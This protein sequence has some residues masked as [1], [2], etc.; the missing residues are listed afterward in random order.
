MGKYLNKVSKLKNW[1]NIFCQDYLNEE[2]LIFKYGFILFN[3]GIFFLASAPFFGTIFILI[4]I[5]LSLINSQIKPNFRSPTNKFLALSFILL[6]LNTFFSIFFKLNYFEEWNFKLN[7]IGLLNWIPFFVCFIFI[8]PYL[9]NL[10]YRT[11]CANLLLIGSLPVI[12]SGLCE[13]FLGWDTT[14]RTL[15]GSI[16]W[17]LKPINESKGMSGLFSNPNYAASWLIVIWPIALGAFIR[18]F[19]VTLKGLISSIT[20]ILFFFSILLTNSKD[21][22]LA[23]FIPILF[24]I[25]LSFLRYLILFLLVFGTVFVIPNNYFLKII[26]Y[27]NSALF[28]D[29]NLE[30]N[31]KNVIDYFPRLDI[32]RVS[33][34]AIF[35]K[36]ILGWGAASFPLIYSLYKMNF[37]NDKIQHSHNLFFETSISYGLIFST[38]IF[39]LFFRLIY[40]SW[41]IIFI[42]NS[43]LVNKSLWLATLLFIFNHMFDV[44][45]YDIRLSMIFWILLASLESIRKEDQLTNNL[46]IK[47]N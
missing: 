4:S 31:L 39:I 7:L 34:I 15:N 10:K 29:N 33:I 23:L 6:L 21:T 8:Q 27:S 3:L 20:L 43:N 35:E 19:K 11:L 17:F 13:Y 25:K 44:T 28:F 30:D 2:K 40:N 45:Y 26:E 16:I 38:I 9:K 24:L 12:F 42:K 37:V 5:F 1:L 46:E 41:K 18:N 22:W 36:P 32:W 47:S 14:L